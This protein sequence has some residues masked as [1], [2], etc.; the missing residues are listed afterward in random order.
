MK[1]L[2][3]KRN[4]E[5]E[6]SHNNKLGKIDVKITKIKKYLL[7]FPIQTLRTYKEM[8]Y[9]DSSYNENHMFI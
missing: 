2:Y 6:E 7:G 5:H 3:L 1:L 8:Y 4:T 9:K